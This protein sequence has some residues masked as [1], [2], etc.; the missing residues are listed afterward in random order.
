MSSPINRPLGPAILTALGATLALCTSAFAQVGIAI[1]QADSLPITVVYPTSGRPA[2]LKLG[3]FEIEAE[4][5]APPRRGN[6]RLVMISHGSGDSTLTNF[7][8]ASTLAKAGFTVALPEHRGDNWRDTADTGPESWK[9]RPLEISR[10]IDAVKG[11]DRFGPLLNVERVGVYGMS[12][13][14]VAAL[15]L[16]GAQWS[17]AALMRHC[18]ERISEDA[19]FRLFRARS[20]ED[21]AQLTRS[22]SGPMPAGA[23][24]LQGGPR[25]GDPRI[26]AVA[27]AV[28]V[29][30]IFTAESLR[31]V[32][33]P[34]GIVEAP[35][36]RMLNPALHSAYVLSLCGAY[37]RLDSIPGAGHLDV[38]A[39]WPDVVAKATAGLRG[40][41]RNA[42]IDDTRRGEAYAR[43]VEF[44]RRHLLNQ[45]K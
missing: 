31:A 33:I 35:A 22:F 23:E 44:F 29:G 27:V 45:S 30:A 15:S 4:L 25:V 24:D 18:A 6:G 17:F 16:A 14:G 1:L 28:P 7:V 32:R 11:D 41:E 20:A 12:A 34:V 19:G 40:A 21:V 3:P 36:D 38:L 8:L 39:P 9:R 13:G 5:G 26:A 10:A 43:V 42:A 37:Q 2:T